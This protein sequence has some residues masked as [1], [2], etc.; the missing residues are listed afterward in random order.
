MSTRREILAVASGAAIAATGHLPK[1]VK[2][3]WF[4]T[5][6]AAPTTIPPGDPLILSDQTVRQVA[7]LSLGGDQVRLRL[8]NEFGET[9]LRIGE[10]RAALRKGTGTS[11][12]RRVTFGGR[13]SVTVPA[14]TALTSDPIALPVPGGADLVVSLHLPD[15]TP[16]TTVAAFA[17]QE[18]LIAAGNVTASPHIEPTATITQYLFLSGVSVSTRGS[19]TVVTLGDSITNGAN[20]E[21]NANHRWPDLL[22]ARFRKAGI[23]LG[24]A[25]VGI[26]G[27]RLLHDPNPPA[28]DPAEEFAAWFGHSAPRR[29]DRD[30]LAQPGASHL[31]VLLGV[32]DLGHPGT[33][34]PL[35]E[36]VSAEDLIWGHR[37]LITRAHQQGI[38]AIGATILPFKGDTLGFYTPE[39][40]AKR[41]TLNRWIRTSGEY[42]GVIDFD[43]AVLDPADPERLAAAFDSGDHLHPNDAGMAAMAAAVPLKLFKKAA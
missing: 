13:G 7:H 15:R 33:I 25:N 31:V 3:D 21:T 30:V 22:A 4:G 28:G 42:D 34:A 16:V 11:N 37:Q 8:T 24:V 10:V 1:K 36:V 27:N 32:N 29:F 39:N 26:S 12:D 18:N 41:Q 2:S 38:T 43:R 9:P 14:G 35:D 23:D 40:A 19:G 20:T 5:W 6:S 17:F